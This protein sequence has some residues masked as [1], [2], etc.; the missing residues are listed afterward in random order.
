MAFGGLQSPSSPAP[1]NIYSWSTANGV[2]IPVVQAGPSTRLAAK[3]V[4]AKSLP[5]EPLGFPR[6]FALTSLDNQTRAM[7]HSQSLIFQDTAYTGSFPG[8]HSPTYST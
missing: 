4:S 1:M 7:F 8:G 2:T 3:T 5:E 6:C